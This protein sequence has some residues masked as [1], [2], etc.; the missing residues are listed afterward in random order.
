MKHKDNFRADKIEMQ[1]ITCISTMKRHN[2]NGKYR[3]DAETF[4]L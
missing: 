1:T 2:H 4:T 3:Q